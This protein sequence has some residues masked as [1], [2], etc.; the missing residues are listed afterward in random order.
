M[1]TPAFWWRVLIVLAAAFGLSFTDG[2]LVFFTTQ[3]NVIVLGY[4]ACA[5]YRMATTGGPDPAAPRLRG[6]VTLWIMITGLVAHFLLADGANPLPGLV[7]D[8][9]LFAAWAVFAV[10]YIVPAMV[11]VDWLVLPTRRASSWRELPLWLLYPLAYALVVEVRGAVYRQF[12]DRYPYYFLDPT[13]HGYGWVGTQLVVFVFAFAA[14]GAILLGL[15]RLT[16]RVAEPL[17]A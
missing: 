3:S 1:R 7:S 11:L 13:E 16:A 12:P 4:F 5:L 15:H 8:P 10:H 9:D 14:L 2:S 6:P 17:P